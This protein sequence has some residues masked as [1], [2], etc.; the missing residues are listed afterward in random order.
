MIKRPE[1]KEHFPYGESDGEAYANALYN[2]RADAYNQ[3]IIDCEAWLKEK[4]A[5]LKHVGH[6]TVNEEIW[7]LE[8]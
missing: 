5:G 7:R 1:K 2:H 6:H 4:I 8:Q 3:A